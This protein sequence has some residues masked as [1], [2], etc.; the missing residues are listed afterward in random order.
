MKIGKSAR[1]III[2]IV[3]L[4]LAAG[5]L[6]VN[7][8]YGQ[9]VRAASHTVAASKGNGGQLFNYLNPDIVN[10]AVFVVGASKAIPVV[11]PVSGI[12]Y[13]SQAVTRIQIAKEEIKIK[14]YGIRRIGKLII[15]DT[16]LNTVSNNSPY[17]SIQKLTGN[18]VE[19]QFPTQEKTFFDAGHAKIKKGSAGSSSELT[20]WVTSPSGNNAGYK[21]ARTYKL[22]NSA[23]VRIE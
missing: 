16:E 12:S 19:F 22:E 23:L 5:G 10:N 17:F 9:T 2:S 6:I 13:P 15:T 1:G 3:S 21:P 7:H 4:S 8:N 11:D 18:E 20:V 14:G